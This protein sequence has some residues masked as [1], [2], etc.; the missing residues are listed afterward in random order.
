M[1]VS[2]SRRFWPCSPMAGPRLGIYVIVMR[3]GRRPQP[4]RQRIG[5]KSAYIALMLFS[6][7]C[8]GLPFIINKPEQA[9]YTYFFAPIAGMYFAVL[10]MQSGFTNF[11]PVGEE[12]AATA[13]R[14]S[15][16]S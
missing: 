3:G 10:A 14:I 12:A 2:C 4:V 15:A 8:N 13:C 6:F 1:N 5:A 7:V 11:I 16:G 9:V